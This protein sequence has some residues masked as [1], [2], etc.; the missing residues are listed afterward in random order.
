M[1]LNKSNI[2]KLNEFLTF[3]EKASNYLTDNDLS[4]WFCLDPRKARPQYIK[5]FNARSLPNFI[6]KAVGDVPAS[7]VEQYLA[8]CRIGEIKEGIF[9]AF[10]ETNIPRSR[11]FIGDH[12]KTKNGNEIFC[13]TNT[14]NSIWIYLGDVGSFH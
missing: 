3:L 5:E 12:T 7:E 8:D 6:A 1:A 9:K 13:H 4:S 11:Y 2:N 14:Q 10:T